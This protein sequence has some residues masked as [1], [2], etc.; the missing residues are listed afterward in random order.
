ML[1]IRKLV[2]LTAIVVWLCLHVVVKF[3]RTRAACMLRTPE[4]RRGIGWYLIEYETS[5]WI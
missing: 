5:Y 2:D 3:F 4:R 1:A